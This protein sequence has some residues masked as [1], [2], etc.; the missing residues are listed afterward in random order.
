MFGEG[1]QLEEGAQGGANG[2]PFHIN[3][4]VIETAGLACPGGP[5]GVR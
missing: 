3:L 4:S 1:K 5:S 2:P